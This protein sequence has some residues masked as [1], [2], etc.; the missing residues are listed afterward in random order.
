MAMVAAALEARIPAVRILARFNFPLMPM[1]FPRLD[2]F[3][4]R[5]RADVAATVDMLLIDKNLASIVPV[6][7]SRMA[8]KK[9]SEYLS[10]DTLQKNDLNIV[11]S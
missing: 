10:L 2:A 11:K 9:V 6:L 7:K 5:L 3:R 1:P 8:M 4:A